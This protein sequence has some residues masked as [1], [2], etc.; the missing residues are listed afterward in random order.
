MKDV[1]GKKISNKVFE[2]VNLLTPGPLGRGMTQE[3][4]AKEL[5]ITER[6]VRNRLTEFEKNHPEAYERFKTLHKLAK[7][8]RESLRKIERIGDEI[9]EIDEQIEEKW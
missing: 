3:E 1:N 4:A 6:T 2:L 5:G 9:D 8:T 7:E